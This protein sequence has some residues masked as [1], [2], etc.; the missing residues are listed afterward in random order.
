MRPLASL[1]Y[2]TDVALTKRDGVVEDR[3]RYLLVKTP[4][5]PE[6]IWGNYLVYPE[7]PT[8]ADADAWID[9]VER[10][11]PGQRTHL[12]GWDSPDGRTGETA[13]FEADGFAL[14]ESVVLTTSIVAKS[15]RWTPEVTVDA[16]DFDRD[17]EDA[18]RVL[19]NAF[20]ANRH[21]TREGLELFIRRQLD[22]Y[23]RIAGEGAGTWFGARI[24]GTLAG[25]LGVFFVEELGRFQLVGTDPTFERRGVCS[26]LVY[27]AATRALLRPGCTKLVMAA[28]ATYHAA[29]VYESV[30]FVPE[31]RLFALIRKPPRE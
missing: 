24:D 28:D 4:E 19:T 18:V 17:L 11:F 9:D 16:I 26:T 6:F 31:E 2:R 20:D 12:V 5:N 22:R 23:A 13:P 29:R 7:P 21:G 25:V 14:D 27:E 30:G 3:E 1:G 15:R 10:E 8:A